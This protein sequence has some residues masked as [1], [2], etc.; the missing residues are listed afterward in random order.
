MLVKLARPLT[1][2]PLTPLI[3]RLALILLLTGFPTPGSRADSA[4]KSTTGLKLLQLCQGSSSDGDWCDAYITGV[5]EGMF[6][7]RT[8]PAR[9]FHDKPSLGDIKKVIVEY[10]V[11]SSR[12]GDEYP[13]RRPAALM[14]RDILTARYCG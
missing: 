11:K 12:D 2:V 9:C 5:V 3:A 6:G 4:E 10:A 7:T 14:I 13:L 8:F 1:D